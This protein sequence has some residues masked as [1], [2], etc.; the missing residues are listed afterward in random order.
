MIRTYVRTKVGREHISLS[1]QSIFS[2][3]ERLPTSDYG[4]QAPGRCL[5]SILSRRRHSRFTV[6]SYYC[7]AVIIPYHTVRSID[8]C[9]RLFV[10]RAYSSEKG[11]TDLLVVV[12]FARAV[13][14]SRL[15]FLFSQPLG[16][17][18]DFAPKKYWYV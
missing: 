4:N 15:H 9:L 16:Q 17:G 5:R 8:I 10:T 7:T 18:R 12:F 14:P 6:Y 11:K 3:G 1:L 2:H 13:K